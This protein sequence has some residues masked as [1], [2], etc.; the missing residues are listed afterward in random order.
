MP[1]HFFP[2]FGYKEVT[3]KQNG[4]K[5]NKVAITQNQKRVYFL[6]EIMPI[7]CQY[8]VQL[9]EENVTLGSCVLVEVV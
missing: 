9:D 2:S 3:L 7:S 1:C 6:V 5:Y 8:V 4:K